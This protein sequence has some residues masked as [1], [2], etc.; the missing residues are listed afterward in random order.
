MIQ[1]ELEA[2]AIYRTHKYCRC[3]DCEMARAVLRDMDREG[4]EHR[5]FQDGVPFC[6]EECETTE[7]FTPDMTK[8]QF[9][10]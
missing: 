3:Q 9:D 7:G 6:W 8:S 2:L 10:A 4:A 5:V 1:R